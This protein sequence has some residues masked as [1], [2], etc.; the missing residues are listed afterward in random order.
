MAPVVL[1]I[2]VVIAICVTVS[3]VV[4]FVVYKHKK[5]TTASSPQLHVI[6]N[7]SVKNVKFRD[8]N[9]YP[10][11]QLLPPKVATAIASFKQVPKANIE[12]V[13]Q[14]GQGF[15]GM[16]FKGKLRGMEGSSEPDTHVAVKTLKEDTN[17]GIEAFV[18]EAKLMFG[19]DHENIVKILAV[20]MTQAPYYLVFEY[21][22][23]G[24]LAKFL[25]ENASSLQRRYMNPL[26]RP[27]SRTESTLSD[28]PA[29]LNQEQLTD[30]CKQIVQGM[31]YLS[32]MNYVHRDLAC[33]NCLVSSLPDDDCSA[34]P[35]RVLVKIGDFGLSHN[36]YSKDYYRVRG[37]AVLPI[38]WMSP[39]AI[40]Y[41]KFSTAG[42]V[43]SFGVVMWEVFTL[44]MQPYYGT[45]NEEVMERVRHG[46]V[47]Q[48]PSDC[49]GR[50]YAIMNECWAQDDQ[51]RP[52]FKE[53]SQCL[54]ECRVSTSSEYD[55]QSVYSDIS[56]DAFLEENS[57]PETEMTKDD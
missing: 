4:G 47:L 34:T 39:E 53:L 44:G 27:R 35:S 29:S 20:S 32:V 14:L 33:R 36:L 57:D 8:N 16:V 22:D 2:C 46:K 56:S 49:S 13:K 17:D 11:I 28:D 52:T 51:S 26:D 50:I 21:M 31:E 6:G 1:G 38:R 45:S 23:K 48:K 10:R 25:R 9:Q 54:E 41:G 19:F 37:Q 5:Q 7:D 3:G 15:F 18:N 55:A 43:W 12:Y 42:D 30:I 40:I 24:D